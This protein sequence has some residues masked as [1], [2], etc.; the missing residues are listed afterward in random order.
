MKT[1]SSLELAE[2]IAKTVLYEGYLLYPYYTG[3]TKN[4]QRWNFGALYPK[5]FVERNPGAD[6]SEMKTELLVHAGGRAKLAVKVRFLHLVER[7]KK[8][9]I[10]D[11]FKEERWEEAVEREVSPREFSLQDLSEGESEYHFIFADVTDDECLC[12]QRP[13]EGVIKIS[14]KRLS[15]SLSRVT[16][17]VENCSKDMSKDRR[18]ALL[19]SLVSTHILFSIDAGEFISLMDTPD[20]FRSAAETCQNRGAWPVLVGEPGERRL[21][22]SAPIILYDH[23][24]IAPESPGD[25]FDGTEIDEILSLRV[26]TL[27]D[28][29]KDLIRAA[30]PVGRKMLERTESLTQDQLLNMH[31]TFREVSSKDAYVN[32][33]ENLERRTVSTED[34]PYKPGDRVRL[35]PKGRRDIFDL[36][37]NDMVASVQ[38]IE[39]DFEGKI[40]LAV[41][42]DCDPGQD[43]GQLGQPGHRFFFGLDEVLPH[44]A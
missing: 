6:A 22:L 12:F 7:K 36:A 14:S 40:H 3:S 1:S 37:L 30:D 31:G 11:P 27:T 42:I 18:E 8:A 2:K 44:D 32:A 20:S 38:T 35:C 5:S 13:V 9:A 10:D 16:V 43:L 23:P 34:L 17:S 29:E 15:K 25:L 26:L 21:M 4:Q 33:M 41:T 19:H 28:N 39:E 24:Q